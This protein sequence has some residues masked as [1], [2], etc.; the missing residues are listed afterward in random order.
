MP[1]TAA[2]PVPAPV[3]A[4]AAQAPALAPVGGRTVPDATAAPTRPSAAS[5]ARVGLDG[6]VSVPASPGPAAG[7]AP[8]AGSRQGFD[9]AT[10][11]SLPAS[12]PRLNLELVRP[13]G[14]ELSRGGSSGVL[15]V[16]PRPPEPPKTKLAE[17]LEKAQKPDCRHAYGNMGLAAVA[18]LARDALTGQGCRW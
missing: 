4:P 11:P 6:A 5:A 14:G 17:E 3:Q 13:R 15:R 9:V 12:A 18:P 10:P 1:T 8:D 16:M 7:G 2:T